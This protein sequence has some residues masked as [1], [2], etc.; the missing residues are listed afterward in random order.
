MATRFDRK[1]LDV[2]GLRRGHL[3]PLRTD[4]ARFCQLCPAISATITLLPHR[5]TRRTDDETAAGDGGRKK[6]NIIALK[7]IIKRLWRNPGN[8][9]RSE[10]RRL[11]RDFN[12][13]GWQ[14]SPGMTSLT[15]W[16]A[17]KS[18]PLR[19]CRTAVINGE[20]RILFAEYGGIAVR[21][22]RR[23]YR[24]HVQTKNNFGKYKNKQ[25]RRT[26]PITGSVLL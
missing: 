22:F 15:G 9:P 17:M 11:P 25:K 3:N 20:W 14:R 2:P 18:F 10:N 8:F 7:T 19:H 21:L 12:L 23:V 4:C 26:V 13:G 6:P 1:L 24:T 5:R 16:P